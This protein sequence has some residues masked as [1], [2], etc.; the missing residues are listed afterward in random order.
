MKRRALLLASP[1]AACATLPPPLPGDTAFIAPG[2][3]FRIPPP[4]LLNETVTV[5]QSVQ[6]DY[7]G[8]GMVFEAQIALTPEGL[9]LVA[10]DGLGRRALTIAWHGQ[11]PVATA[12]PWLPES[13]TPA[14][15]LADIAL[16]YWPE[17]V[18]AP[19]LLAAG[20]RLEATTAHRSVFAGGQEVVRIDY[21]RPGWGGQALL[22]NLAFGYS[23]NVNSVLLAP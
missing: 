15:M 21:A 16:L 11:D 19:A 22:R 9:D 3:A 12:A 23:L 13:V 5:A 4:S 8:M 6:A 14:N 18:L 10:L 17:V 20:A 7:G 2:T 1:L